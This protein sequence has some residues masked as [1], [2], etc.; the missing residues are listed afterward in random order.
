MIPK[1]LE[2]QLQLFTVSILPNNNNS[3]EMRD[4]ID[5]ILIFARQN[6]LEYSF[7]L[8]TL[9][10]HGIK[11]RIIYDIP[12]YIFEVLQITIQEKNIYFFE[13]FINLIDP[14]HKRL[15]S[16]F[17]VLIDN[18]SAYNQLIATCFEYKRYFELNY[19]LN[20][21]FLKEE[22]LHKI[23]RYYVVLSARKDVSH[24]IETLL[25]NGNIKYLCCNN[26]NT[27]ENV[28]T[29][30]SKITNKHT[31]KGKILTYFFQNF[32][33]LLPDIRITYTAIYKFI[34]NLE[35]LNQLLQIN[36]FYNFFITNPTI[37][38]KILIDNSDNI[39]IFPEFIL[40]LRKSTGIKD[41]ISFKKIYNQ[42]QTYLVKITKN[43]FFLDYLLQNPYFRKDLPVTILLDSIINYLKLNHNIISKTK[44][45]SILALM[46]RIAYD[47]ITIDDNKSIA[48]FNNCVK[49][50]KSFNN[51]GLCPLFYEDIN[52]NHFYPEQYRIISLFESYLKELE[53]VK[54]VNNKN[55]HIILYDKE[56]IEI[57]LNG[58]SSN[59]CKYSEAIRQGMCQGLVIAYLIHKLTNKSEF[60]NLIQKYI[61]LTDDEIRKILTKT[62][63]NKFK[64]ENQ[65]IINDINYI[66][67]TVIYLQ[68]TH[69]I[70]SFLTIDEDNSY[71]KE[72]GMFSHININISNIPN[73]KKNLV[74]NLNHIL[75]EHYLNKFNF[76]DLKQISSS[77]IK[78]S[79]IGLYYDPAG[80]HHGIAIYREDES[81]FLVYEP[82]G[83]L[84]SGPNPRYVYC[85]DLKDFIETHAKNLIIDV[86]ATRERKEKEIS[87]RIFQEQFELYINNKQGT[88]FFIIGYSY[89]F[90]PITQN[91]SMIFK[92]P[93]KREHREKDNKE[94]E[95]KSKKQ[96]IAP[97]LL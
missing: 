24:E 87:M 62:E 19:M 69:K 72:S 86:F 93:D 64:P 25:N 44:F 8:N 68:S 23:F 20:N 51:F 74:K 21:T 35:N 15:N 9:L 28:F 75:P 11:N 58:D 53:K 83:F 27:L 41:K 12:H 47:D 70:L 82:N 18:V 77:K 48:Y 59:S 17:D 2:E 30:C 38:C 3:R 94:L 60:F 80:L 66:I 71:A 55:D 65:L 89:D 92:R 34:Y 67:E 4:N 73:Q 46:E 97:I 31:D 29:T 7:V 96:K 33:F 79:S 81:G 50:F 26:K 84:D 37:I 1:K 57:L 90:K 95:S 32:D 45:K 61:N 91:A 88:K 42:F 52:K 49:T 10:E 13:G 39:F 76:I 54:E 22:H 14:K 40:Y 78:C 43:P 5:K 56:Y 63:D 16:L 6:H 85:E 36:N